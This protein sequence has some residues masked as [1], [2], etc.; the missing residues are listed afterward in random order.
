MKTATKNPEQVVLYY[1]TLYKLD[2]KDN[3]DN[4]LGNEQCS[5]PDVDNI[6]PLVSSGLASRSASQDIPA[7]PCSQSGEVICSGVGN[8]EMVNPDEDMRDLCEDQIKRAIVQFFDNGEGVPQ[9][10][11]LKARLNLTDGDNPEFIATLTKD[12]SNFKKYIPAECK[13]QIMQVARE[14]KANIKQQYN[15][16]PYMGK[17][18]LNQGRQPGVD[19]A[20]TQIEPNTVAFVWYDSINGQWKYVLQIQDWSRTGDMTAAHLTAAQIKTGVKGQD[21]YINP[22]YETRQRPKTWA[23]IRAEKRAAK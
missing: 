18:H 8:S 16:V 20:F 6:L 11:K 19:R 23:E 15:T 7:S 5:L 14:F 17:F 4:I 21:L 9:R 3:K 2:N 12:W 10:F 22:K 13:E 1:N